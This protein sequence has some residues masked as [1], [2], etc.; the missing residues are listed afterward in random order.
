M[1]DEQVHLRI[2]L[3][4]K[5]LAR[6]DDARSESGRTRTDEIVMRLIESFNRTDM[7]LVA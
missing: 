1:A 7:W 4:E 5:L 6:I 2:R 3:D